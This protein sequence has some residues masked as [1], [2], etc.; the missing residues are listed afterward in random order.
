[1][2]RLMTL[3]FIGTVFAVSAAPQQAEAA[4]D[5]RKR[6]KATDGAAANTGF[7]KF[8]D[9]TWI[10]TDDNG[11][12]SKWTVTSMTPFRIDL[13]SK[14]AAGTIYGYLMEGEHGYRM[15]GT[16]TTRIPGDFLDSR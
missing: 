6:W 7:V 5:Y 16:A 2:R 13:V 1:M 8:D 12:R 15:D 11:G 9:R 3:V 4:E 10:S 14:N